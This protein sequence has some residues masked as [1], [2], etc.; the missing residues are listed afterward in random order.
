MIKSVEPLA[1]VSL[2]IGLAELHYQSCKASKSFFRI[3]QLLIPTPVGPLEPFHRLESSRP[4]PKKSGRVLNG[5]GCQRI[6]EAG[7]MA[8]VVK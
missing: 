5:A 6:V 7:P 1:F 3:K 2:A 4:I 8:P